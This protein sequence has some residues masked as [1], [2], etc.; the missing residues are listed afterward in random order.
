MCC[1]GSSPN[2]VSLQLKGTGSK[3]A[4]FTWSPESPF[5]F[6]AVNDAQF[7]AGAVPAPPAFPQPPPGTATLQPP[8][9]ASQAA[10]PPASACGIA[11]TPI[12]A[13]QGSGSVSPLAG[14]KVGSRRWAW[15]AAVA[16]VPGHATGAVSAF[17]SEVA[18]ACTPCAI[19]CCAC[20][21]VTVGGVVTGSFQGP[22]SVGI[23]AHARQDIHQAQTCAMASMSL[24]IALG[25]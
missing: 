4:D 12:S 21:Q 16:A 14:Q 8:P 22:S 1:A 25:R 15:S 2:T 18:S 9:G 23:G 10:P 6:G 7:F 11:T 24:I 13:V 5:S 17:A 3:N 20:S 19:R